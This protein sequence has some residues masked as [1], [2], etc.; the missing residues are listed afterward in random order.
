MAHEAK[1]TQAIRLR[2]QKNGAWLVASA[3]AGVAKKGKRFKSGSMSVK[4]VARASMIHEFQKFISAPHIESSA[5]QVLL[6]AAD[7]PATLKR[8]QEFFVLL[9]E[10]LAGFEEAEMQLLIDVAMPTL[11]DRPPPE[12]L[13]QARR[14]A[15]A[16][17]AFLDDHDAL[18]A[19]QVHALYGSR[20]KNK[21]ALAARWRAEG[22]I[23]A[24]EHE[25][26]LL[27]PAFQF[28]AQGRPRLVV[29][30]LL[31]ILAAKL[32]GW[33]LV[34]WF[35]SRNGWLDGARPLDLLDDDPDR[36]LDAA[37]DIIEPAIF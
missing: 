37:N 10:R 35:A 2:S 6:I 11:S 23:F 19:E 15:Q 24:V 22:K 17:K 26:S 12:A 3:V 20:A 1:L 28:D 9:E 21:S 27:Y 16:R 14:N 25:G 7:D 13:E 29:A 30:D 36:V 18:E 33:Q 4:T 8:M 5:E 32:G 34:L 31:A